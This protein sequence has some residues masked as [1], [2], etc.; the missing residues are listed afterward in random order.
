MSIETVPINDAPVAAD[1]FYVF[2][3]SG[4]SGAGGA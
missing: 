2:S 1:G 3:G 4:F